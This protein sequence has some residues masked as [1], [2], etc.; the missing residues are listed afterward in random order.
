VVISATP[1]IEDLLA[2]VRA[3]DEAA[4]T[5]QARQ[6][7]QRQER[8]RA[9]REESLSRMA[10]RNTCERTRWLYLMDDGRIE[11]RDYRDPGRGL[12]TENYT[13]TAVWQAY[14]ADG[15]VR[16]SAE[17][18][19]LAAQCE[20]ETAEA[21]EAARV[22]A[23]AKLAAIV[24]ARHQWIAEHGSPRLRRMAAEG[25]DHYAT[26]QR[27]RDRHE[28]GEF[29][30]LLAADRPGWTEVAE[31]QLDLAVADVSSRTLA[32]LDAARAAAPG[33]RLARHKKLDRYVA[34]EEY[35]GRWIYWPQD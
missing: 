20:A 26:Y 1:R 3:E 30:A 18:Q 13:Y 12:A 25:I 8:A 21:R 11:D 19:A 17:A 16:E 34:V 2:A 33:C 7:A 10:E 35:Q 23:A 31:G 9:A 4:A 29:A 27:E 5:Y 28:A 6:E 14:L 32:L 15:A 22:I 24:E